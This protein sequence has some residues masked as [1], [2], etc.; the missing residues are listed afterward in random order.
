MIDTL[1]D[2]ISTPDE[3]EVMSETANDSTLESTYFL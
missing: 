2:G 1:L 3:P